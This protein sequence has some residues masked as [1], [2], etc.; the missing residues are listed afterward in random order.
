[1]LGKIIGGAVK[2]ALGAVVGDKGGRDN[3][4]IENARTNAEN[5]ARGTKWTQN[6]QKGFELYKRMENPKAKPAD[7][8]ALPKAKRKEYIDLGGQ[9]GAK[10]QPAGRAM[11][12]ADGFQPS[13]EL[14]SKS[15]DSSNL[16]N[17]LGGLA[18]AFG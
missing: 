8:D 6:E 9:L 3:K 7:F 2:G 1:M 5:K 14:S 10:Q 18:Q 13:A 12:A 16:G 11:A 4:K 17:I 15:K